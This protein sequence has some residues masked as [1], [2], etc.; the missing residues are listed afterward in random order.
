[1]ADQADS[2]GHGHR[3]LLLDDLLGIAA[4]NVVHHEK[5]LAQGITHF[6]EG[7]DV[8]V[9]QLAENIRLAEKAIELTIGAGHGGE[10]H[11]H[12]DGLA[13]GAMQGEIDTPHA[14]PTQDPH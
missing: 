14:A 9:L 12:G 5:Q 13:I 2:S 3:F 6:A 4:G 10:N 1:M 8:R 7:N 11:L